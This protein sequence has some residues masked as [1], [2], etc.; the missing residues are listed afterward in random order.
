MVKEPRGVKSQ[1]SGQPS[2]EHDGE[3]AGEIGLHVQ[4]GEPWCVG[5]NYIW[6]TIL[7]LELRSLSLKSLVRRQT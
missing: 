5:G 6:A 3:R 2:K 4:E 7:S 1:A